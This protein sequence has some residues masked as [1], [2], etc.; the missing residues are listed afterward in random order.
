[1]PIFKYSG[2]RQDGSETEGI[3]EADGRRDAAIKVK[4]GGIFPKEIGDALSSRKKIFSLKDPQSVLPDV[5]RNLSTLLYSGA[6]LVEALDAIASE[7]KGQWKGMLIDIKDRLLSGSALAKALQAYPL[8]FPDFYSGMVYAGESSGKLTEVLSKLAD[9]LESQR[10]IKNKVQTALVYPVFMTF[11]SLFILSFL[12]TFVVP[13]IVRIFEG[14][15]ATLP[16][17][18]VV[19]IWISTAFQKFWWLMMLLAAGAAVYYRWLKKNRREKIDAILL[20]L[21]SGILQSLYMSRFAMTMSFLIYGG[22]S[23]IN[24]MQSAANATGNLVLKNKI[25]SAQILVSQGSRIA[26]SLEGFPPTLLQMISTGED[27][28]QLAETL[29]RA[30]AYYEADFDKKLSRAISLL[31][32]AMILFMGIIVSFIVLAVL[33]PIFELNQLIRM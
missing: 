32:P 6:T 27:S 3:I 8:I 11:I 19:L 12:F 21:P 13:K 29:K 7:Q 15:S 25:A 18:T 10:T 5:T 9:F 33:L 26:N 17:I 20:N 22:L 1:M 24:A 2:Y 14:T 16:L 30:A 23:V 28:G 4:A 31:E